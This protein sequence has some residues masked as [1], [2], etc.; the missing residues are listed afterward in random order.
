MPGEVSAI[1]NISKF[2]ELTSLN[3][4][5]LRYYEKLGI[6]LNVG[7]DS[8]GRRQYSQKNLEWVEFIVE[9]KLLGMS[10]EQIRQYQT[11]QYAGESTYQQRRKIL[12][13]HRVEL[14]A[15]VNAAMRHLSVLD[16]KMKKCDCD[17]IKGLT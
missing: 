12:E 9:L 3:S 8:A 10:L 1:V 2:S 11:L 14:E 17:K 16:A 5:T 15:R 6:L 13:T 4:H 7:R